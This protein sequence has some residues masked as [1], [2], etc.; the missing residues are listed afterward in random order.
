MRV[1]YKRCSTR[2]GP[3]AQLWPCLAPAGSLKSKPMGGTTAL[4]QRGR[5]GKPPESGRPKGSKREGCHSG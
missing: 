2:E 3:L 4:G 5:T 1:V